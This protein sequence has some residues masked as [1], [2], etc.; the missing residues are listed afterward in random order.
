MNQPTDRIAV[1]LETQQW[2]III[3]ALAEAPW[4]LADPILR[5]IKHQAELAGAM[6]DRAEQGNYANGERADHLRS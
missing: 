1:T 6:P 5:E 2:N 3:V 4:K